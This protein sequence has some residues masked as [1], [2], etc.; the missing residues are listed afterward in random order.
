MNLL[1]TRVVII[2]NTRTGEY[3]TNFKENSSTPSLAPQ[4][5]WGNLDKAMLFTSGSE[6]R[7]YAKNHPVILNAA[8]SGL[9]RFFSVP[10]EL[11]I[12]KVVNISGRY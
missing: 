8:R 1:K 6:V 3:L 10:V 4:I 2:S 12:D 11:H 5:S 7:T 9:M